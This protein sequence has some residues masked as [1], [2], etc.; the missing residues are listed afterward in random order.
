MRA[1][2]IGQIATLISEHLGGGAEGA[3][4]AAKAVEAPAQAAE[5]DI[6]SLS[7]EDIDQLL[8]GTSDTDGAG[9]ATAS[10]SLT[11]DATR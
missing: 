4:P 10:R 9:D 2:T 7:D 5:V 6:D 8:G 11:A 1:R 3:A